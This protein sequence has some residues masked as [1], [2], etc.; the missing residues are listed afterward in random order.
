MDLHTPASGIVTVGRWYYKEAT[1]FFAKYNLKI[2]PV[3]KGFIICKF[4][5]I[6]S[7]ANIKVAALAFR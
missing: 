7:E 4:R 1:E 3:S 5:V 2:E 6:G